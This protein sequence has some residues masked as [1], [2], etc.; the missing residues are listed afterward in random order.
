MS[1]FFFSR[2]VFLWISIY[3]WR[4]GDRTTLDALIHFYE[5]LAG[6]GLPGDVAVLM[7][8]MERKFPQVGAICY[9][10]FVDN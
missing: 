1:N 6:T 5:F 3:I 2:L 10:H 4:K 9:P 8:S 7:L